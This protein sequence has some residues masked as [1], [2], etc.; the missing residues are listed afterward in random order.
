MRAKASISMWRRSPTGCL[1]EP[2]DGGEQG[3]LDPPLRLA[4]QRGGSVHSNRVRTDPI[5][6]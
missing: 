3:R 6:S 2:L 5:P 1:T 4:T